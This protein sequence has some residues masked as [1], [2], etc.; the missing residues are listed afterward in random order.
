MVQVP[1]VDGKACVEQSP[2][3]STDMRED[4]LEYMNEFHRINNQSLVWIKE[5]E[6][7]TK[8]R[9]KNL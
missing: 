6:Y 2:I 4:E 3:I 1:L 9:L 5:S 7:K 8:K